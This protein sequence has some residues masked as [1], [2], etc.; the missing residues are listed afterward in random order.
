MAE[1]FRD[2]SGITMAGGSSVTVG[3]PSVINLQQERQPR[4][5]PL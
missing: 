4:F 5:D 3:T 2:F 1:I